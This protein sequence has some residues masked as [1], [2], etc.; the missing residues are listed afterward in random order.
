[1][2]K[3]STVV[4]LLALFMAPVAMGT[5]TTE[6]TTESAPEQGLLING[7]WDNWFVSL[8]GGAS[9]FFSPF[10]AELEFTKRIA[11]NASLNFGKWW[12]P[13]FGT[14]IGLDYMSANSASI[15]SNAFGYQADGLVDG[16]NDLYLQKFHGLRPHV[17]GMVDLVNLFGGYNPNRI[18]S[19][20]I[21]GG[22]GYGYGW[23]EGQ[24]IKDGQW[25]VEIRGG[26]LNSFHVSDAI[27]IN[28]ELKL[29]KYDSGLTN[30]G[31]G[32]YLPYYNLNASANIGIAYNFP[33]RGWSAP[34]IPAPVVIEA[35]TAAYINQI[36]QLT[37]QLE[38][39]RSRIHSLEEEI[40][41]I[42]TANE[43]QI[44][45]VREELEV[46]ESAITVYF[47][48]NR[49]NL[50]SNDRAIIKA[51]AEAIKNDPNRKY[52]VTGYADN[53]T[54]TPEINT[55]LR[56]ERA[57]AVYNALIKYGVNADQLTT[58]IDNEPLN[59]F[60]Y[61]LDRATTIKIAK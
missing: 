29:S 20:I 24:P 49:S 5:T 34:V 45:T 46:A 25:N 58:A 23:E 50:D 48:I 44:S 43:G 2:K 52:V 10:D 9:V 47:D 15:Y 60:N 13:V 53:E 28:V 36:Q 3:I 31:R 32:E 55:R 61:V 8:D 39:E 51:L 4:M 17:D 12:T 19:L 1:M 21:Y 7:F 26:L 40:V 14:R 37:S 6:T 35:D 56:E 33:T 18:Y 54:G 42:N 57:K 11:P 27:D 16:Y 41:T 38:A 30:E 59:K 22:F